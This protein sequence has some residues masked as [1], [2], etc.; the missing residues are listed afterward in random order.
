MCH[1]A[2][3]LLIQPVTLIRDNMENILYV[4]N[5]VDLLIQPGNFFSSLKISICVCHFGIDL[6]IRPV[7]LS[8]EN[9]EIVLYVQ[10]PVDQLIQPGN[11]FLSLKIS[12]CVSFCR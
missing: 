3:D 8:R 12:I 1:F 5:P 9:K 4:Q 6:L 10:N 11:L 7:T 2:V